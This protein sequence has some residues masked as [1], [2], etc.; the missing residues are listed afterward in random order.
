MTRHFTLTAATIALGLAGIAPAAPAAAQGYRDGGYV[1]RYDQP[2]PRYQRGYRGQRYDSYRA[3]EACRDGDGGTII[4]AIAGGLIGNGVA[5]R[6]DRAAGTIIG[7]A[8]GALA[9]RAID[10]SDRP[11][12][13]RR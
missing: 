1:Q 4:G 11:D 9:G 3:R 6:G 10:R 8:L 12:Y 5:G 7:G 2:G 13:C